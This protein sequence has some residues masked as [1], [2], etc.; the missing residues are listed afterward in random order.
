MRKKLYVA[1]A[2]GVV[3]AAFLQAPRAMAEVLITKAESELP[4]TTVVAMSMRGLTRGPGIKQISPSPDQSVQSPLTLKI[5]FQIRNKVEIDPASVK[6]TYMKAK[7]IDL[8]DR[9]EKHIM[10]DGIEMD[11]AEVPP[12]THTLQL[13]LKDKQ[14]RVAV[15]IIKLKVANKK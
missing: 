9:I 1:F 14:G 12:G 5:K 15:A 8:T 2:L 7:P 11:Q 13:N 3:A 10:P 6:L 4:E